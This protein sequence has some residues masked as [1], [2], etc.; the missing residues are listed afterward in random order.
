M[1]FWTVELLCSLNLYNQLCFTQ[2]RHL[3]HFLWWRQVED[4]ADLNFSPLDFFGAVILAVDWPAL[5]AQKTVG[6]QFGIG[7]I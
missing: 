7:G 6:Q 4:L 3:F 2:L 1:Q 5:V